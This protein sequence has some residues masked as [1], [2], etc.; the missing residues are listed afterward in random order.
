M[1]SFKINVQIRPYYVTIWHGS[2]INGSSLYL[3]PWREPSGPYEVVHWTPPLAEEKKSSASHLWRDK[4]RCKSWW[5]TYPPAWA[6][7]HWWNKSKPAEQSGGTRL[8]EAWVLTPPC[9]TTRAMMP[10]GSQSMEHT[11]SSSSTQHFMMTG[12]SLSS[13]SLQLLRQRGRKRLEN[14]KLVFY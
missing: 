12:R 1:S 10:C 7:T 6:R 9:N 2:G 14:F 3:K 4:R 13:G 5:E 11:T 8:E